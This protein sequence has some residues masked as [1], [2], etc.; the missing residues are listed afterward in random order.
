VDRADESPEQLFQRTLQMDAGMAR[1]LTASGI[2]T[3]EE[4]AYVPMAELLEVPGLNEADA[5]LFRKR[6]HAYLL[7]DVMRGHDDGDAVDA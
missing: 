4:L 6:A 5:Q 7:N 1:V 2:V 3:L